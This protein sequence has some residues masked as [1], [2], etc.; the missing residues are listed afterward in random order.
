MICA[1]CDKPIKGEPKKIDIDA[2]TG[3]GG[4]VYV[5]PT[6]CRPTPR[7]TAPVRR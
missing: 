4:T 7:Q 2:A 3:P 5:C 6:L 1:R